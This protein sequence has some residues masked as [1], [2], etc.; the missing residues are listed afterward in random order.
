MVTALIVAVASHGCAEP[1]PLVTIENPDRQEPPLLVS[2][3]RQPEIIRDRINPAYT[4][5]NATTEPARIRFESS[6]CSCY[7]LLHDGRPLVRGDIFTVPAGERAS[8]AFAIHPPDSAGESSYQATLAWLQDDAERL[9]PMQLTIA[10]LADVE[11]LPEVVTVDVREGAAAQSGPVRLR[12]TTRGRTDAEGDPT[13]VDNLP[14]VRWDDWRL[15]EELE[16]AP[17]LWRREWESRIEYTPP[18]DF[19]GSARLALRVRPPGET[20]EQQPLAVTL[21]AQSTT[22]L[23]AP[24][25]LPFGPIAIGATRTRRVL[26]SSADDLAFQVEAATADPVYDL[27]I[28]DDAPR[29]RVWIE[30]TLRPDQPGPLE[31]RLTLKT[32]HPES[33]HLQIALTA[34]VRP[35]S[36]TSPVHHH[37]SVQ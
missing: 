25:K 26:I 21:L 31:K 8:V 16:V 36:H 12:R 9:L 23:R 5:L 7:Q 28:L 20:G 2:E 29:S 17:G 35:P 30:V 15:T 1:S 6:G 34:D 24:R 3:F 22:G 14:E 27:R 13:A 33:R 37:Q 19:G 32:T 10:A 4:I 18:A 11:L